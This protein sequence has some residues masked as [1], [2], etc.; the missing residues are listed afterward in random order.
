MQAPSSHTCRFTGLFNFQD[1]RG[2][3]EKTKNIRYIFEAG[4]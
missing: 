2:V 1:F 4:K 3:R